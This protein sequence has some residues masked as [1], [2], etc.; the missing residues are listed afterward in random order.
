[1]IDSIPHM[2]SSL[3]YI[4]SKVTKPTRVYLVG[5]VRGDTV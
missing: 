1:M 5:G 2:L 3:D 4:G